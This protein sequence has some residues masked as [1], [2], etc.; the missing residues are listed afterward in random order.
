MSSTVFAPQ[1]PL[2]LITV[3][4][5]LMLGVITTLGTL[6]TFSSGI[7][8]PFNETFVAEAELSTPRYPFIDSWS[9]LSV[10][11]FDP[12]YAGVI[13][14]SS[15]PL[16]E[17][18]ALRAVESALN[19]LV[20]ILAGLS[21]VVVAVGLL[22]GRVFTS[23]ARWMIGLL[24]VT[25]MIT[26][27]AAP[28]LDALAVDIAVQQLGFPIFNSYTDTMMSEG[29]PE[30]VVLALWDPL[31]ALNRVDFA[32]FL[33]GAVIAF[34]GFLVRDG[35]QLLVRATAEAPATT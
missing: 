14:Q 32:A 9:E 30:L 5:V 27:L 25:V 3:V 2:R 34:T 22:R 26:A 31:W 33:L 29:S 4:L 23:A 20:G 13:I 8:Q 6:L 10:K 1:S 21:L 15:E 17:A 24:G 16:P 7:S 18:R 11:G 12:V 35:L 28:Q 19:S